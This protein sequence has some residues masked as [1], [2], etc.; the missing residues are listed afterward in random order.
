MFN[1]IVR[2]AKDWKVI[3]GSKGRF[4]VNV[5]CWSN[6]KKETEFLNVILFNE[7]RVEAITKYT[8]KGSKLQVMGDL[9]PNSYEAKCKSCAETHTV[10]NL[11]LNMTNF[12]FLDTRD[13]SYEDVAEMDNTGRKTEVVKAKPVTDIDDMFTNTESTALNID[14]DDLPF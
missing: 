2:L 1:K 9:E 13:S 8:K 6:W 4:A 7:K 14:T 11:Q 10:T 3:E 12:E 5:I